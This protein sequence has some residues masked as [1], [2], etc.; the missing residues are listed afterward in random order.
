MSSNKVLVVT[1]FDDDDN[2][3]EWFDQLSDYDFRTVMVNLDDPDTV[4]T[5]LD[6]TV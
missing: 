2:A 6:A 1:G 5:I 3:W 4:A